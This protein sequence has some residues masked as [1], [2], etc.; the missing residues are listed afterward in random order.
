M[1][2]TKWETGFQTALKNG[3]IKED[4]A[5]QSVRSNNLQF[6]ISEVLAEGQGLHTSK[7]GQRNWWDPEEKEEADQISRKLLRKD[8]KL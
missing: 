2:Q 8:G 1:D 4:I 7:K 3:F 6:S 5:L